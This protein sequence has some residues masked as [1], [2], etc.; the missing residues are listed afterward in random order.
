MNPVILIPFV[1]FSYFSNAQT[2][3]T[4]PFI[5]DS[6]NLKD[7]AGLKKGYWIEYLGLKGSRAYREYRGYYQND[8]KSQTWIEYQGENNMLNK[9]EEFKDGKKDGLAIEF[10]SGAIKKEEWWKNNVLNGLSRTYHIGTRI[11]VEA[12]YVNGQL[13]GPRNSWYQNGKKQEETLYA[14]G[15]R[16]GNT[17]WYFEDGKKSV[18]YAYLNGNRN[19]PMKTFH[20]AEVLASEGNYKDNELDGYFKEYYPNG[21]LKLEG[22]YTLGKKDGIWKEYDENGI[23]IK[24]AKFKDG[25]EGKPMS[26]KR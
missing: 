24:I 17:V 2:I 3:A 11:S 5:P 1:I 7:A 4:H 18:E 8:K 6:C 25:A 10:E 21:K 16:E 19:G 13:H 15:K 22:N 14:N 23:L 26:I 20:K 12:N 9:V